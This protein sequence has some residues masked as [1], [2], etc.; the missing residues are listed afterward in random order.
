M[1]SGGTGAGGTGGGYA[2][3]GGASSLGSGTRTMT[4]GNNR[5]MGGSVVAP[6]FGTRPVVYSP[7]TVGPSGVSYGGYIGGGYGNAPAGYTPVYTQSWQG[8]PMIAGYRPLNPGETNPNYRPVNPITHPV[9]SRP[10][11]TSTF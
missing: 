6:G 3:Y 8:D 7:R 10:G 2:S 11:G 1:G 5:Q 9:G 4:E